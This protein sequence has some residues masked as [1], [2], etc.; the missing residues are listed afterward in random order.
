MRQA[1]QRRPAPS[2]G[3]RAAS[4]G[5]P[6]LDRG[7]ADHPPLAER[8]GSLAGRGRTRRQAVLAGRPSLP[9]IPAA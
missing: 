4:P 5:G 9:V 3:W 2:L 6:R 7:L 8:R 1:A